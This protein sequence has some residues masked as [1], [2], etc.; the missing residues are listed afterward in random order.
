MAAECAFCKTQT[1][2]YVNGMPVCIACS[3]TRQNK[4]KPPTRDTSVLNIL[5][6]D[7]EA[8]TERASAAAATFDAVTTEI[9]SGMPHPDGTQR[10]HNASREMSQARVGLMIAHNRLN[11]YLERAVVPDDLKLGSGS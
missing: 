4:R 8:A 1:E 3:E 2:L 7:L 11:D 10:I 9:P 5:Q 6:R